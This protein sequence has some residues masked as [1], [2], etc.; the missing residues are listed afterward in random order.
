MTIIGGISPGDTWMNDED[1]SG[2]LH[3]EHHFDARTGET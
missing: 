3:R 1:A 2:E